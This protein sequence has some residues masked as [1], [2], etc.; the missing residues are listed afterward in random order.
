MGEDAGDSRADGMRRFNEALARDP[1]V[2]ATEIQVV[3]VKGHDG[4][5]FAIVRGG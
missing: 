5:A 3:G 2:I 4:L 1:R